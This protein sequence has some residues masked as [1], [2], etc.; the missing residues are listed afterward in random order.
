VN[1]LIRIDF[2]RFG[3]KCSEVYF[4]DGRPLP[5]KDIVYCN[6]SLRLP[7]N[8]KQYQEYFTLVSDL[9]ED[10]SVM[11]SKLHSSCRQRIN[12]AEREGVSRFYFGLDSCISIEKLEE[13]ICLYN[14]FAKIKGL[15]LLSNKRL[16]D[17]NKLNKL[18]LSQATL[19][20]NI[21]AC[22]LYIH[23]NSRVRGLKSVS[24]YRNS[25]DS[26]KRSLIGYANRW[27]HWND[28]MTFK[29]VGFKEYDWGGISSD[30]E[31]ESINNFKRS[32]GGEQQLNYNFKI[33]VSYKAKIFRFLTTLFKKITM[34]GRNK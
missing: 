16:H 6:Q 10:K 14:D 7:G 23:D 20:N 21:L 5:D 19:N 22:H 1:K 11:L 24:R 34:R 33:A 15:S 30:S 26:K 25:D 29:E 12:R 32:F 4:Y 18:I 27:L 2:N 13:F 28:M 9:T 3:L 17:Y 31:L 8:V